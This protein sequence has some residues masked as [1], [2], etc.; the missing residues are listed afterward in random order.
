MKITITGGSGFI[1]RK[2]ARA[3]LDD[4]ALGVETLT[5]VD[6]V[7]P[8]AE[9]TEDA[10]VRAISGDIG[11]SELLGDAI[12]SDT[13]AVFHLAAV[14]SAGAEED[15]ELGK[16]VNLDSTL[17]ILEI[18]RRHGT[19]PKIVFASS[20]AAYGGDMPEVIT[21]RQQLTPQT[22]YGTQKAIGELLINDYS[23]RGFIDG[24]AL[25]YP[26]VVVRPGKPNKAASTFASSII[27]EPLHGQEALCPVAPET[28]MWLASPRSIVANTRIAHDLPAEAWATKADGSG[29]TWRAVALPGFHVSVG[30]MVAA[31]ERVAGPEVAAR[32]KWERDPFIEKIVH[33][34][35]NN[36]E[37][38]RADRMGFRRDQDMDSVIRAFIEDEMGGQAVR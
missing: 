35:P 2:L 29:G 15:F 11:S 3:L 19:C 36:F 25:R 24:R 23:R 32:V 1:G 10:R 21:D 38:P 8:P 14:V 33:G 12:G 16:T 5:M 26:T 22:S 9:L 34:W 30:E 17:E 6:M 31:L 27:R 4:N 18:A 20:C 37:T 13:E 28:P 7:D